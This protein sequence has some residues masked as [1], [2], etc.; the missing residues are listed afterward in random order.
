VNLVALIAAP[1]LLKIDAELD[2]AKVENI[3]CR[4]TEGKA[5][6]NRFD[7]VK[8]LHSLEEQRSYLAAGADPLSEAPTG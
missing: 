2:Y 7:R 3:R 5:L 1:G 6:T 8:V 4:G